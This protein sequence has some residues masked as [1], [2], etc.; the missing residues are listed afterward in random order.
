MV[1]VLE[2]GSAIDMPWLG[3]VPA[4]V[5]AWYP[6]MVGGTA[7]G[8]LLFGDAN[9]SGK[10]PIT[11]PKQLSDEPAFNS[12]TTT[13]FDYYAGYHYFDQ[14]N[15]TPLFA[16]GAGLS[17]AS[18]KYQNIEV[19]CVSATDGSVVEVKADITNTGTVDGDEV[20]FLFISYPSS[21]VRRPAKELKGFLRETIKAGQTVRVTIP[22]RISDLKYWDT[23]SSSWKIESGTVKV[24]VGGSSTS[25]PISDTFTVQ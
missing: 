8:K 15:I 5:M 9:F 14:N 21:K 4:V 10:L 23:P 19:P 6:G 20:T 7:L 11:W 3:S 18:F 22:L 2:G 25:L 17:Y 1:V 13:V 12:G 16:F 24:M